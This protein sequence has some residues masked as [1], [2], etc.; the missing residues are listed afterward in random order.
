VSA[1]ATVAV[2]LVESTTVTSDSV[3]DPVFTPTVICCLLLY[4]RLQHALRICCNVRV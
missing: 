1:G 2:I 3:R 4:Y